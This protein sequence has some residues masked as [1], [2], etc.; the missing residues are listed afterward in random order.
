MH[1]NILQIRHKNIHIYLT[2]KKQLIVLRTLL[3]YF[4][5]VLFCFVLYF[6]FCCVAFRH[7]IG[8]S[9]IDIFITYHIIIAL[10][11]IIIMII[12]AI[13]IIIII[14]IFVII[15][16]FLFRI[17]FLNILSVSDTINSDLPNI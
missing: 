9:L 10:F 12:I 13:F 15:I 17:F 6:C 4:Y 1:K 7:L 16:I 8:S 14:T 5:I 3:L 11:L 2:K